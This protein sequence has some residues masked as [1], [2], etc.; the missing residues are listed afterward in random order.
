MT[1]GHL[2]HFLTPIFVSFI[3]ELFACIYY[4]AHDRFSSIWHDEMLAGDIPIVRCLV[5]EPSVSGGLVVLAGA[6]SG[7]PHSSTTTPVPAEYAVKK[8][9]EKRVRYYFNNDGVIQLERYVLHFRVSQDGPCCLVYACVTDDSLP[10]EDV[11]K[12]LSLV[13]DHILGNPAYLHLLNRGLNQ[14]LQ[15]Q[16]HPHLQQLLKST[17]ALSCVHECNVTDCESSIWSR[18]QAVE[19]NPASTMKG[20][21]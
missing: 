6:E 7:A 9:L 20:C 12:F 5:C 3:V 15:E 21:A 10:A 2:R 19:I 11:Q 18:S 8:I 4:I 1:G 16:L 14:G 17:K 13:K